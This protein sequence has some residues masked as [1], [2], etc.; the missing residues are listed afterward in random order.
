MNAEDYEEWLQATRDLLAWSIWFQ[1]GDGERFS[2][3]WFEG[4]VRARESFR[5]PKGRNQ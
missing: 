4:V 2:M 5:H 3:L 1:D